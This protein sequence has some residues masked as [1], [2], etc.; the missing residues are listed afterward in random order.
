MYDDRKNF[1]FWIE[2]A[3][4]DACSQSRGERRQMKED[5]AEVARTP[6][7]DIMQ[8]QESVLERPGTY[9][10]GNV[11]RIFSSRAMNLDG[12]RPIYSRQAAGARKEGG[13]PTKL[14]SQAR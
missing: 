13:Q 2:Q 5:L 11:T 9:T 14:R 12:E 3:Y 10:I 7:E 4:S 6:L 1:S 8:T